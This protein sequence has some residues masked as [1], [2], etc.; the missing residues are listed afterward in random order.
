MSGD[1]PLTSG[2]NIASA[3]HVFDKHL[4]R[5]VDAGL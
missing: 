2:I 1:S 4:V 3:N 5:A